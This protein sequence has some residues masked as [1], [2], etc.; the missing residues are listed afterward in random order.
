VRFGFASSD[1]LLRWLEDHAMKADLIPG[2]AV[3][4][5]GKHSR[6]FQTLKQQLSKMA[7]ELGL[8]VCNRELLCRCASAK[9]EIHNII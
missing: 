7:E 6:Y 1:M 5:L 3:W 4:Q 8:G 9:N 2:E